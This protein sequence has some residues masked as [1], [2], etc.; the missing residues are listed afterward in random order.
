MY[1]KKF[2]LTRKELV[3]TTIAMFV[4]FAASGVLCYFLYAAESQ[5]G[6]WQFIRFFGVYLLLIAAFAIYLYC[7]NVEVLKDH[8][9]LYSMCGI[10]LF[11]LAI[12]VVLDRFVSDYA[13]PYAFVALTCG[14]IISRKTGF[15]SSLV[16]VVMMFFAQAF[17]DATTSLI[18]LFEGIVQSLVASYMLS[19]QTKRINYIGVAA[20]LS[21]FACLSNL[22][23]TLAD[24]VAEI[25]YLMLVVYSLLSGIAAVA[26]FMIATPVLDSIFN[27]ITD[28][29]LAELTATDA[30]LLKKMFE[31]APGTFN[32]CLTVANYAEACASAIGENT[33]LARAAAYYH[34]IGKL[35]NPQYFK[36]NQMDGHNPHDEITP[37][38]STALIK[39]HVSNGMILA[40]EYHLPESVSIFIQEHHGTMPI[41][42]FYSKAQKY[43]DGRLDDIGFRYDGPTPSNKISAILMVCDSSEAALRALAPDDRQKADQIV[44]NI[45][46]DR[47]K[48][49][50]FDNCDITMKELN[51]I[52]ETIVTVFIG[53]NHKRI[54]Y[55]DAPKQDEAEAK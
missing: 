30:P 26:M 42:F 32:H 29:R 2:A 25:N 7:D 38:L 54:A 21:V 6:T 49:R 35:K 23:F 45:L 17:S 40:K 44:T 15:M 50:Q 18:P 9:K 4:L 52:K 31:E 10:M 13:V 28:F 27:L 51:T 3:M 20:G 16:V 47:I 53:I 36:E 19:K 41:Q 34:D 48:Y 46:N 22:M 33:Y 1:K 24:G 12:F 14:L 43:T 8:R 55:P 5:F 39:K 11:G 37:E